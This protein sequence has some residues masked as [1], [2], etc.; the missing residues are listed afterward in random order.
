VR[1]TLYFGRSRPDGGTVSDEE[2]K[3]FLA[4]IVTPRFPEGLTV[5][6]G[7]RAAVSAGSGASRARA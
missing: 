2:W 3:I 6:H 7:T 5:V 4:D 1:E